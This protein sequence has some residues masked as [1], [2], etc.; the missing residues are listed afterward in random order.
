[1]AQR[2]K[3]VR[4]VVNDI[5]PQVV[6]SPVPFNLLSCKDLVRIRNAYVG[7]TTDAVTRS[8]DLDDLYA[9]VKSLHAERVANF[10]ARLKE[11][12]AAWNPKALER[13]QQERA[14]ILFGVGLTAMASLAGI[15]LTK[16][17][18][19]V[20][21]ITAGVTLY[22]L[23]DSVIQLFQITDEVSAAEGIVFFNDAKLGSLS[24]LSRAYKD[25]ASSE[26]IDKFNKYTWNLLSWALISYGLYRTSNAISQIEQLK[27][28]TDL[29]KRDFE[30]A[31]QEAKI[32]LSTKDQFVQ[33]I[34]VASGMA[35]H[36]TEK[37]WSAASLDNCSIA[38][39]ISLTRLIDSSRSMQGPTLRSLP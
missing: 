22:S 17:P 24:V 11:L 7:Q 37:F 36:A 28:L 2:S 5:E 25:V 29:A 34:R 18:R 14:K 20:L 19:L 6:P 31:E 10:R 21:A 33:Y 8:P 15:L 23:T 38:G 13:A 4:L 32:F 3:S 27:S 35:A 1:M 26:A 39:S 12:E 30:L 9:R 16:N